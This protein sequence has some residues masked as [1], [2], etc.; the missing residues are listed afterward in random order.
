MTSFFKPTTESPAATACGVFGDAQKT[1]AWRGYMGLRLEESQ[2]I[3]PP[4]LPSGMEVT[5]A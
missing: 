2:L 4:M 5:T 3:N 1:H